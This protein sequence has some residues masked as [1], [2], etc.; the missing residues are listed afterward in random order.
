MWF[1]THIPKPIVDPAKLQFYIENNLN[2][3]IEGAHGVGKT[4]MVKQAFEQAGLR[5]LV[6]GGPT[7]DPWVDFVGVPR[8]ITLSDGSTV[9][10]LVRRIEFAQ[11]SVDAIF[12][13]EFNRAPAK[14]RN[15]AMEILQ[16]QS[17]NGQ[18]FQRLKTVW[19]AINPAEEGDYDTEKLDAAQLDRFEVHLVVPNRPCPAYFISN[20]GDRGKAAMEWW[21]SL[22][23]EVQKKVSP[24]RLEYALKM[25]S[26]DGRLGDVLP[27]A[28]NP[29]K[30][31]QMLDDGPVFDQLKEL[32]KKGDIAGARAVMQNPN[33]G[34]LALNH[35]IGSRVA[36]LFFL[37]LLDKEKLMSLLPNT[38]VLETV[39]R[40]SNN[41]PE[42]RDALYTITKKGSQDLFAKAQILARKHGVSLSTESQP[43]LCPH[44][45]PIDEVTY[46]EL[47]P[48]G[49]LAG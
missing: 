2:V 38:I 10:E 23:S 35:I 7:M 33:T 1:R 4:A 18:R 20:F 19:A 42:F 49:R 9:L 26:I 25:A 40:F 5:L 31:R 44:A 43:E 47:D 17:V 36:S 12:I 3:L 24:R 11:D 41:V 6:F 13:D 21:D 46:Q 37:P 32:M 34:S 45:A 22:A 39:V 15:A 48:Y 16:F 14:V 29:K 30:L 27:E 8:P 28:S